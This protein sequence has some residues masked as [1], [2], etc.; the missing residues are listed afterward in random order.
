[1][2]ELA[3]SILSAD[4]MHL[5]EQLHTLEESGLKVLHVDVMDGVFVPSISFGMPVIKSIRTGCQ[6]MFD[7]HLMI[8]NPKR[9]IGDFLKA[10]ADIISFHVEAEEDIDGAIDAIVAGGA[11]PALA[12]KPNTPLES[13]YPYLDKLYMVLVMTVEPGFGGQSF[14]ADMMPKVQALKEKKPELIVQVDGG[15][16]LETIVPSA[17]AGVDCCVA[18]T[19]VFKA[20]DRHQMIV[21]LKAA[22]LKA[23]AEK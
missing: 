6:M 11:K 3:P 17:K 13:V 10:G 20:E 16:N 5:G 4:F 15:I 22:A 2:S 12:V 23:V 8:Q 14:M 9:Y 1:M 19:S 18:G 21:D 7:V